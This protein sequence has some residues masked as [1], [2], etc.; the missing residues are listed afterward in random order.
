MIQIIH[1]VKRYKKVEAVRGIDMNI[2]PGKVTLLLGPNGAGKSS[3]V[4]SMLGLCGYSGKILY[5]GL[6]PTAVGTK[7]RIGYVP[8][9]AVGY[10]YMTIYEHFAYIGIAYRVPDWKEKAEVLIRQ[11]KLEDEVHKMSSEIS[12]G[13]K[14][15][16]VICCALLHDPYYLILDEPFVGLDANAIETMKKIIVRQKQA[17]K[18]ILISTHILDTVNEIWDTAPL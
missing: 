14:Q 12:K 17:G 2:A 5:D 6:P 7:A 10:D 4:K 1:L 11:F 8:E 9:E 18:V 15:K 16:M 13:T 3:T